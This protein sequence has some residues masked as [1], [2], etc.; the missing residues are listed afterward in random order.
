[1]IVPFKSPRAREVRSP[2]A[3]WAEMDQLI[4]EL[5]ESTPPDAKSPLEQLFE[6]REAGMRSSLGEDRDAR[7][8]DP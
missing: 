5:E 1:M 8:R 4:D 3:F 2:E 7:N 6:D